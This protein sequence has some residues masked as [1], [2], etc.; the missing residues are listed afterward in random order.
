ME[1]NSDAGASRDLDD[2]Q[3]RIRRAPAQYLADHIR[4]ARRQA[5]LSHD[6]LVERMGAS[7][8]SGLIRYEKAAHR[9]RAQM[10]VSIAEATGRD[11]EWFLPPD[12]RAPDAEELEVRVAR[13]EE[14]VATLMQRAEPS[15]EHDVS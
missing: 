1:S 15:A 5:G 7:S 4:S 14:Q 10:L 8:R 6:R 2:L 13:L 3:E 9:P 11:V 12:D